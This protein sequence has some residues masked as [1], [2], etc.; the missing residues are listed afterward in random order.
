MF[1]RLRE[2]VDRWLVVPEP[3]LKMAVGELAAVGKVE[4]A[5]KLL[6]AAAK[7]HDSAGEIRSD[8]AS[9]AFERGDHKAA[10]E[11]AGIVDP[12][13]PAIAEAE[14]DQDAG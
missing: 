2:C 10:E 12:I 5:A 7:K 3:R 1:D 4:E 13:G 8:L 11:E 9:L 6:S 14:A